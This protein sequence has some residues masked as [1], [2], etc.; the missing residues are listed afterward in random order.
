[1]MNA[2]DYVLKDKF[3]PF[4]ISIIYKEVLQVQGTKLYKDLK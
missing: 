1:M 4:L 2:S 3:Y